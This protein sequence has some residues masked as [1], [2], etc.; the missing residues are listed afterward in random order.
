M[1]LEQVTAESKSSDKEDQGL[2]DQRLF[3][4]LDT[5]VVFRKSYHFVVRPTSN[6]DPLVKNFFC[7]LD[8]N[9]RN[10]LHFKFSPFSVL[11]RS[12]FI[13]CDKDGDEICGR[14]HVLVFCMVV[15]HEL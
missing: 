15:N 11:G 6:S 8:G 12:F 4:A 9:I 2:E 7:R 1:I 10:F 3:G 14:R 13:V 5:G